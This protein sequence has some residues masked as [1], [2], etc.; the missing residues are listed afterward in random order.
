M[1]EAEGID[2][3]VRSMIA[4]AGIPSDEVGVGAELDH[5]IGT[6]SPGE[7]VPVLARTY[8]GIDEA[9]KL[10][11]TSTTHSLGRTGGDERSSHNKGC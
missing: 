11:V 3:A 2:H 5:R 4:T 10:I 7:G 8:E 1:G 6:C 9:E